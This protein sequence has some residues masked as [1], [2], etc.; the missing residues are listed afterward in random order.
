VP[1]ILKVLNPLFLDDLRAKL[2]EAGDN[3]RVLLNLRKRMSRIR[4]FDPACGSGNFLVIA[5]KQLREIEAELN[6]RRGEEGR[7]SDMSI[8]VQTGPPLG[9]YRRRKGTPCGAG[10]GAVRPS[11]MSGVCQVCDAGRAQPDRRRRPGKIVA[12]VPQDGGAVGVSYGS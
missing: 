10:I 1:N 6:K 4:V 5:Y 9:R 2:E 11:G 7:K 12:S 3:L 8:G